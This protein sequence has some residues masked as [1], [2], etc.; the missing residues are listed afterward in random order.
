MSFDRICEAADCE[1]LA[2]EQIDV[3]AGKFGTVKLF[4][5]PKCVGKFQE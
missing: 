1:Q 3:S 2:T 5:C 4:V